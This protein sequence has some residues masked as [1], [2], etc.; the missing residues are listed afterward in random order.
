MRRIVFFADN[1]FVEELEK[2]Y[3]ESGI[4]SFSSYMRCMINSCVKTI[5]KINKGEKENEKNDYCNG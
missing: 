1:K 4:K 5:E 3:H 2:N